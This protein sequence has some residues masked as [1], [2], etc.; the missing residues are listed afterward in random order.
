MSR[1]DLRGNRFKTTPRCLLS[2]HWKNDSRVKNGLLV[3]LPYAEII[4]NDA[5][6]YNAALGHY[7]SRAFERSKY[8]LMKQQMSN[9]I[10]DRTT[11]R[12]DQISIESFRFFSL[13]LNLIPFFFWL[14]S[15][16]WTRTQIPQT[17]LGRSDHKTTITATS[18]VLS[19][20]RNFIGH[21]A[22]IIWSEH[23]FQSQGCCK[24]FRCI[25]AESSKLNFNNRMKKLIFARA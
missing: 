7:I 21:Q 4:T 20:G 16:H 9:G 24:T 8:P 2:V 12:S 22:R 5:F 6:F 14:F 19:Y 23:K 3:L 11:S 18:S 17:H 13:P 1:T 15:K 10:G 25:G